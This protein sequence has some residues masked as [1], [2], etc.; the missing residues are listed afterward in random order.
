MVKKQFFY[1]F[2]HDYRSGPNVY[3]RDEEEDDFDFLVEI[4]LPSSNKFSAFLVVDTIGDN[5]V[6][7]LLESENKEDAI[8][9]IKMA[10]SQFNE[11]GPFTVTGHTGSYTEQ[12]HYEDPIPIEADSV[13]VLEKQMREWYDYRIFGLVVNDKGRIKY[14]ISIH[15]AG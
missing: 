4:E 10:Y 9:V 13:K 8:K 12:G 3:I 1:Q 14:S 7:P 15:K 2:S 5:D 11:H 6:Y